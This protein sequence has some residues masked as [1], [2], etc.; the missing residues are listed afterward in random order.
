MDYGSST[1]RRIYGQDTPPAIN[2]S[3][4]S[5]VPIAMFVGTTDQLATVADNRIAKEHLKT[6]AF[7][8][9]YALGHMSFLIAKDMH[10]FTTDVMNILT[11]YHSSSFEVSE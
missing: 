11:Q 2:L 1:N 9:E 10:Y 4:I 8:K 6:L 3:N 7:Y 5:R